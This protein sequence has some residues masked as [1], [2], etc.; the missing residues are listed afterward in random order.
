MMLFFYAYIFLFMC[1]LATGLN[2]HTVYAALTA[3]IG[4]IGASI[5]EVSTSYESINL[6]AK[7]ILILA[8]LIGRIE[9]M[10][11]FVILQPSYWKD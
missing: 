9:I 10:T 8:M 6:P 5:G 4:N 1:L 3:S 11:I 7:Y 2:F